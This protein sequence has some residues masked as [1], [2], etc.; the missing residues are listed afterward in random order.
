MRPCRSLWT[1]RC[2]E[3]INHRTEKFA[4][5]LALLKPWNSLSELKM[6]SETFE[7]SFNG[8]IDKANKKCTI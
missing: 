6:D 4:S 2:Q 5:M 3:V 1:V 8:F 7:H